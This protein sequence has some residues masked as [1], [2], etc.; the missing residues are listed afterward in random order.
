[1]HSKLQNNEKKHKQ[2]LTMDIS[3]MWNKKNYRKGWSLY[4]TIKL[5][6][7]LLNLLSITQF[8][9]AE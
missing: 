6:L 2:Y 5:N 1:M 4:P 3:E 7:L 9:A 8:E